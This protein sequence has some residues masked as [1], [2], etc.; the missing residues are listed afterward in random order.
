MDIAPLEKLTLTPTIKRLDDK[1]RCCGRKP[2]IYK[3]PFHYLYCDRCNASFD[4]NGTQRVNSFYD[5]SE[6]GFTSSGLSIGAALATAEQSGLP[7]GV[8][9]LA[10]GDGWKA[11]ENINNQRVQIIFSDRHTGP[12]AYRLKMAGWRWAPKEKAWQRKI[13]PKAREWPGKNL[14]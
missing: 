12:Q 14:K 10:R 8:R 7:C 4:P 6:G 1:G 11:V 13:T 5:K 9:L 2:L 3:K